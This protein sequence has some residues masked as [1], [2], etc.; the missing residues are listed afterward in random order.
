MRRKVFFVMLLSAVATLLQA[1]GETAS[2]FKVWHEANDKWLGQNIGAKSIT[3]IVIQYGSGELHVSKTL[4]TVAPDELEN[5][6]VLP[7][8]II[9]I[10]VKPVAFLAVPAVILADGTV[11]GAARTVEGVDV[12]EEIFKYRQA[13]RDG[14]QRLATILRQSGHQ[15]AIAELLA[16][17]NAPTTMMSDEQTTGMSRVQSHMKGF[18]SSL[19]SEDRYTLLCDEVHAQLARTTLI[20]TRRAQ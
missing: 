1:Q 15:Q 11:I 4:I 16:V 3:A 5:H 7:K 10:P 6:P 13:E 18:L 19:N 2:V 12:V 14:Y 20:S 17:I 9:E 8:Q